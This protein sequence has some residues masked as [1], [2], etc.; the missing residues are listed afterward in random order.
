MD[1]IETRR[2]YLELQKS[3]LIAAAYYAHT[4]VPCA[5]VAANRGRLDALYKSIALADEE[6]A[7]LPPKTAS[8]KTPA[9]LQNYPLGDDK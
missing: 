4:Q 9:T 7:S 3:A 2:S 5:V 1:D 8:I 6:L